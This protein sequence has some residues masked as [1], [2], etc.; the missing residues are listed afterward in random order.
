[1]GPSDKIGKENG[2][3][4]AHSLPDRPPDE[5]QRLEDHLLAVAH[6][7]REFGEEFGAGGWAYLACCTILKN[8]F[9]I[10]NFS[11]R[12]GKE[13]MT[14]IFSVQA[15]KKA[16]GLPNHQTIRKLRKRIRIFIA[17]KINHNIFISLSGKK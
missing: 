1:M 3:F 6:L 12:N 17:T 13:I 4:Y 2:P 14:E 5:W 9:T 10:D 11:C 16:H 15:A 7:A 8:A